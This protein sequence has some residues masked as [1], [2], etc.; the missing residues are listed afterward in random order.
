MK[1]L[2]TFLDRVRP[3]FQP[4]GRMS[5]FGSVFEG[6]ESF[7]YTPR[8]TS[9][10][11][12]ATH[13]H[14]AID[15]KRAMIIVV[16]ALMPC[17]LFGMYNTG[18]QHWLAAGETSFPF[19]SLMLYG[20]LAILPKVVVTYFVGLG[21]EFA[22]AQIRKEEIQEGFLVT[23]IL[24][25]MICPVE[26]PL[27]ML[28]VATAFAVIFAKEVFG[29]TGYNVVNVALV[30]RAFLFFAYPANMSGDD[31]FVAT[32]TMLGVGPAVPDGFTC[33]TPLGQ[34]AASSGMPAPLVGIGDYVITRW[35]AFIGLIPGSFGETSTLCVLIGAAI[36]LM[37]GIGS[38]RIMLS[39][40]VGAL[41]M[42]W[43]ANEFANPVY[44]A[45]YMAP[46]DQLL[47]GGLAFA[48]VFM[49]TD[50][51]TACRT[52]T[53]KLIYGFL[54]GVIAVIIRTY[55]NGY[56]EGAMLAVLLMNVFS[57]LI[58]WLVVRSNINR[59]RARL[60]AKTPKP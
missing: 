50:P 54:I 2:R 12:M 48:G 18:Y 7:L 25:P 46:G 43:I 28:A 27:W 16:L 17:F 8:T 3:N 10:P 58:D 5:A 14:D 52:N 22:V 26:T 11:V 38:W 33:A 32:G 15:S 51:V 36:L 53:G 56:P 24:I 20:L 23:G 19:W 13:I 21:I 37:S 31:V 55:N 59:R 30:A 1:S 44:P 41:L 35:D 9:A 40:L 4:G 57:S 49:A 39:V 47:Y 29:G 6:F 60:I 34:L 42:G 45:S